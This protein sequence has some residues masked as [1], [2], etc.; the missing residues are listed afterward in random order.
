MKIKIKKLD[1]FIPEWNDN[2]KEDNPIKFNLRY[3][4]TG[5]YDDCLIPTANKKGKTNIDI[6]YKLMVE[7]ATLS[8]DNLSV[9]VDNVE[10][11]IEN[12]TQL[13]A[14]PGM[15]ELYYELRLY[16][17]TMNARIDSKN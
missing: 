16:V 10:I 17:I 3:I 13:L 9:E 15:Q 5:E 6:D 7:Y 8:I 14:H 2:K 4:S 12:A 1:T 11:K